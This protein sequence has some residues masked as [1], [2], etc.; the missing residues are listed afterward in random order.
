MV[1]ITLQLLS[2]GASRI[3]TIWKFLV[4]ALNGCFSNDQDFKTVEWAT[5]SG[6]CLFMKATSAARHLCFMLNTS[7]SSCLGTHNVHLH[8]ST[9][10]IAA[11]GTIVPKPCV[12]VCVSVYVCTRSEGTCQPTFQ[13]AA[14]LQSPNQ[15]K[16]KTKQHFSSPHLKLKHSASVHHLF[17]LSPS[18]PS[19]FSF[20]F[21]NHTLQPYDLSSL[22]WTRGIFF[23]LI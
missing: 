6:V 1:V 21:L 19:S 22:T 15:K 23:V 10:K 9:R 18:P 7:Y 4:V 14:P 3:N 11:F 20:S 13:T 12:C 5:P 8:H 16:N 17:P 2:T